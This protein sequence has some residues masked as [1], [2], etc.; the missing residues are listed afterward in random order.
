M[1]RMLQATLCFVIQAEQVL[2]GF[3][4]RGFGAGKYTGFGGKIEPGE[5]P[6]MTSVRELHEEAGLLTTATEHRCIA[7]LTFNFPSRPNWDMEVHVFL[8]EQ[9][10]GSPTESEEMQPTWFDYKALPY[11]QMWDDAHYWLPL[12]LDR[13]LIRGRFVFHPDNETVQHYHIGTLE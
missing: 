4:K 5:S 8:V 2:L 3:K 6:V 7:L 13:S 11:H 10:V 12:V 1:S 9:W